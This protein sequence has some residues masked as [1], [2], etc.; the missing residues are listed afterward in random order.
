MR[1]MTPAQAAAVEK[2]EDEGWAV[3]AQDDDT[4]YLSKPGKHRGQ[5]LYCQV[6]EDGNV[7]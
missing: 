1:E 2:L 6:D 4:V 5:T 7:N 3:N